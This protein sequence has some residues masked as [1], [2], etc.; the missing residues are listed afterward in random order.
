MAVDPVAIVIRYHAALNAF[1]PGEI[2]TMLS[3]EAEYHSPSVG[4]LRGRASII[5]AMS[6]YFA[7]YPDQVAQDDVVELVAPDAVRCV[8]HL[9][10]TA[11]STGQSYVR[12]GT[13]K[14][15][16]DDAGR[17]LRVEVSDL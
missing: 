1:D 3:P 10:A 15:T 2:E 11:K 14:I 13:E 5:N 7:E 9:Q 4:V 17:I 12:R 8:W 16:L 6:G